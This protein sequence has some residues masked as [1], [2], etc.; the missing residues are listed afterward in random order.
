MEEYPVPLVQALAALSRRRSSVCYI[1]GGTIRDWFLGQDSK[2]LDITVARDS[3]GW[4]RD[5]AR[6][7]DGTFVPMDADEDVARV[8]WQG[9][10]I[11]FSSFREGSLTIEDDLLRRDF[12]INSMAAPFPGRVPLPG[13]S[14][15][16]LQILDPAGGQ[17]DLRNRIIRSTSPAVF[18]SDPLRLLRAYRFMAIFG[19]RLAPLTEKQIREHIHLLFLAAGE[20]IGSELEAI[21]AAEETLKT[22]EAMHDNG[23]LKELLPELYRGVGVKQPP[24]HHLDVFAHGI[25]TLRNMESVQRAPEVHFPGYGEELSAYLQRGRRRIL[26][27]WA[28]LFHDLGKPQTHRIR[29]D[30]N[31]RITFYDHD[32]EGARIFGIIADRFRWSKHDRDFVS[33]FIGIHMWPFHL[34]NARRNTGL[35]PKAYLR[36]I[37]A[38]GEEF[39]GLFMLAMADSLA[40]SGV[41]KP[42]GMEADMASLFYEVETVYRQTIRPA[43][44]ERLLTGHDL[45]TVFGLEPGPGFREIFDNLESAQVE[46]EVL[47]REQALGWVENYLKSHK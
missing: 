36:L 6:D 41:G 25:E 16:V 23:V 43:L 4:A 44:A 14:I 45:I 17:Q 10:S 18:V 27:K 32:K 21:M 8:V 15:E 47:D 20:R 2:D 7:L 42:C 37:K 5:L 31:G 40:G 34:N 19:F 35:T 46:G 22:I 9:F 28:A 3:F 38:V 39:P 33:R 26:L 13:D 11:D 1:A 30:R 29:E 12:T 24:S